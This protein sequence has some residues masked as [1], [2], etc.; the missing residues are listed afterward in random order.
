MK[1]LWEDSA[2]EEYLQWQMEDEKVLNRI[3]ELLKE[4]KRNPY[5]GKGKPE[6][7]KGNLKGW[8]SRRINGT[9]RIVYKKLNEEVVVIA[10][11]RTH[12]GEK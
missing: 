11:C 8:W 2:W 3:N 5:E 1:L 7:L 9:H 12:Y 4:I 6:L 10:S